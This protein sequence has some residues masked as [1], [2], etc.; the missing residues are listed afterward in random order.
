MIIVLM[1]YNF[2]IKYLSFEFFYI[3][4]VNVLCSVYVIFKFI[5]ED[6][7]IKEIKWMWIKLVYL[8]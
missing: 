8:G 2:L 4:F 1:I 3:W 7:E 6:L 5:F